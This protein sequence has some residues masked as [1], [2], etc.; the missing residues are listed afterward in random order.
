MNDIKLRKPGKKVFEQPKPKPKL[1][2]VPPADDRVD[3]V[4]KVELSPE[5]KEMLRE[6]QQMKRAR[7]NGS[8]DAPDAA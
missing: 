2:L 1:Q 8:S 3:S 7:R 6:M 4:A 5:V